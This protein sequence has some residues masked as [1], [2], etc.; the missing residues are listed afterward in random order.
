VE[1]LE[2]LPGRCQLVEHLL[3][4]EAFSTRAP[5]LEIN[6][7]IVFCKFIFVHF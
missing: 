6:N 2:T 4:Y 1:G 3:D 7:P 5:D